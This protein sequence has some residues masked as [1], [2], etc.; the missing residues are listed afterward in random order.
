MIF[1]AKT[2]S[3]NYLKFKGARTVSCKKHLL[4]L[5]VVYPT[6]SN[7]EVACTVTCLYCSKTFKAVTKILD[8]QATNVSGELYADIDT[9]CD[10]GTQDHLSLDKELVTA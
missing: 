6:K 2:S 4:L 8:I 7:S 1:V 10:S 9:P 5:P 3:I